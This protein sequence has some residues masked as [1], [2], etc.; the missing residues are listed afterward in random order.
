MTLEE[1]QDTR[2]VGNQGTRYVVDPFSSIFS[3]L[4]SILSTIGRLFIL[5]RFAIAL[6]SS[7]YG[8]LLPLWYLQ[9]FLKLLL[10]I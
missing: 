5:F 1:Q 2:N 9:D 6:S 10:D 3:F 4:C 7:E 8:F